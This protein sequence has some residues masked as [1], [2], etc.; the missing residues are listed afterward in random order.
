M[1][2]WFG[3]G[4]TVTGMS[5]QVTTQS[6]G[7]SWNG[8]SISSTIQ[9]KAQGES[10]SNNAAYLRYL[11]VAEVTEIFMM[12][13]NKGWFQGGNEGTAGVARSAATRAISRSTSRRSSSRRSC[14]R[15]AAASVKPRAECVPEVELATCTQT[16]QM[17]FRD[18]HLTFSDSQIEPT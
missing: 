18:F 11:L 6:N 4:L 5:V 8:T 10:Y 17:R 14:V 1:A 2:G 9:L 7:A 13:Q 3:G 12:T 16:P 15:K